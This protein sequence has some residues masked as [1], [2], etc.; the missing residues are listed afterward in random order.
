MREGIAWT[1]IETGRAQAGVPDTNYLTRDG[2]EGWV[3]CKATAANMVKFESEQIGWL[4]RRA[5][6]GGRAFVAVRKQH[7]GGRRLGLSCDELHVVHCKWI[8]EFAAHGLAHRRVI[9]VGSDGPARWD[10]E[11]LRHILATT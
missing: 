10:W 7:A 5:R 9:H 3:E 4:H 6:Y 8:M 11:Q 1:T 2:V